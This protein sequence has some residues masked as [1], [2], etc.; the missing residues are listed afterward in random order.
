MC[1]LSEYLSLITLRH[2]EYLSIFW[3][4]MYDYENLWACYFLL[5]SSTVTSILTLLSLKYNH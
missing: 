3:N 1:N 5:F 4:L 2:K